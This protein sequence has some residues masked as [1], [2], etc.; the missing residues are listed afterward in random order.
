MFDLSPYLLLTAVSLGVG[1]TLLGPD[2]SIPFIAMAWEG[3][4]SLK[5][6]MAVTFLCGLA[7]I[8]SSVAIGLIA[9]GF[10]WEVSRAVSIETFRGNWIGWMLMG[11]GL[12]YLIW[13]MKKA[14]A[15]R[16]AADEK[17]SSKKTW[18]FFLLFAFGPCEPLI[19]LLMYPASHQS[20]TSL[21]V[22]TMTFGAATLITMLSAVAFGLAGVRSISPGRLGRFAP[23]LA[24]GTIFL[25]GAA[26]QF[27][28]L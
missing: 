28:G 20:A 21:L 26:V 11:F 23:A 9:I 19:P 6:T 8:L 18:L 27:L 1:H 13:G 22:V 17:P 4:W 2:H 7:H 24:G 10:K 15:I 3:R 12:V 16:H 14:Y 5:K 25:C